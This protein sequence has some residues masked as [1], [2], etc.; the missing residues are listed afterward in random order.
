MK[1]SVSINSYLF[2]PE[3]TKSVFD[4]DGFYRTG[5]IAHL[6]NDEYIYEGRIKHGRNLYQIVP[7][8]SN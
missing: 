3:L 6:A 8:K 7:Q 2:D 4:E 5:D 1:L